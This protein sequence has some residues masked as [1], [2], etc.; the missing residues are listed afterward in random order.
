M[1]VAELF[2]ELARFRNSSLAGA[3]TGIARD[4]GALARTD[5]AGRRTW[6]FARSS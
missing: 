5:I 1:E 6:T 3:L 2:A 4:T